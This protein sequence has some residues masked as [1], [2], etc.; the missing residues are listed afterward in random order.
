MNCFYTEA[1][2]TL[3]CPEVNGTTIETQ[4]VLFYLCTGILL[5]VV[6]E[7]RT[8]KTDRREKTTCCKKALN[9]S[10]T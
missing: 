6:A 9:L 1:V 2:L 7:L 8:G 3:L 5:S 10:E 4:F